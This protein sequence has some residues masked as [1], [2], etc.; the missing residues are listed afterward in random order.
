MNNKYILRIFFVFI[1]IIVSGCASIDHNGN[2]YVNT[3]SKNCETYIPF[4]SHLKLLI[5]SVV[6]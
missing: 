3:E 5:K 6:N 2:A 1:L 4:Y